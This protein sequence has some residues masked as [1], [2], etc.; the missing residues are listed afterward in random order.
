MGVLP[1]LGDTVNSMIKIPLLADRWH[2]QNGSEAH[3][4]QEEEDGLLSGIFRVSA[5][6][7]K[8]GIREYSLTGWQTGD[9]AGFCVAYPECESLTAWVGHMNSDGHFVAN[10]Q[11]SIDAHADAGKQLRS[12]ITGCDTF[13][14]GAT[15]A[16]VPTLERRVVAMSHPVYCTGD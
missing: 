10:W 3:F 15:S 8:H 5:C 2:N 6:C 12:T 11:M 14:P 9:I 4:V 1:T 16:R 13:K 7:P